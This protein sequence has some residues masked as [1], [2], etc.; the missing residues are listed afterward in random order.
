[1]ARSRPLQSG[2]RHADTW[3]MR[4]AIT[5]GGIVGSTVAGAVPGLWG[6]STFSLW[7]V[8]LGMIGGI[9]GII[10]VAKVVG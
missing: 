5:L 7:G 8:L 1:M 3:A 2:L 10:A 4:G 9:A 6:A